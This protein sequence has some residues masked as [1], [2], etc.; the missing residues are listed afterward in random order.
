M[1][2]GAE[3]EICRFQS[4]Q[5]I[6]AQRSQL[7]SVLERSIML[8]SLQFEMCTSG[9]HT[10]VRFMKKSTKDQMIENLRSNK[11]TYERILL[12]LKA[13]CL[14]EVS[15]SRCEIVRLVLL[16]GLRLVRGLVSA[17]FSCQLPKKKRIISVAMCELNQVFCSRN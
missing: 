6:K 2:Y 15:S 17:A 5:Q 10:Q 9:L 13:K 1:S 12:Q 16:T 7:F 11:P 4:V 3:S 14:K 8:G